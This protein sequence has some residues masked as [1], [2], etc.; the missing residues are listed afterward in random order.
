[1]ARLPW[2]YPVELRYYQLLFEEQLGYELEAQFSAYPGLGPVEINDLS[3]DQSFFD[4]EHPLVLVYRKA[5]DLSD[6]EWHALFAEQLKAEPRITREGYEAPV[7]L[8]IPG[9]G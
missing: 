8:P 5:R 3:A 9:P 7:K 6:A 4:Y 2:R 1:V